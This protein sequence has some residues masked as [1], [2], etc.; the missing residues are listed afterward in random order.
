M[1]LEEK[2]IEITV[3]I[4]QDFR[5]NVV[6]AIRKYKDDTPTN[7][8]TMKRKDKGITKEALDVLC[9]LATTESDRCLIKYYVCKSQ[10]LSAKK[11]KK[12]YGFND[13]HSKEDM[14]MKA[15]EKAQGIRDAV[16]QL[17]GVRNKATL[18]SLG[19]ELPSD[20]SDISDS[21]GSD[22]DQLVS[23]SDLSA[24]EC[25]LDRSEELLI[26]QS[27]QAYLE[28]ER[29]R[30]M[31]ANS[32]I[33]SDSESDNPDNWVDVDDISSKHAK[34]MVAKQWQILKR[35][36]QINAAKVIAQA[37]LLKRRVTKKV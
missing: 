15:V 7:E 37:G 20:D 18:R 14:I 25:D 35:R 16:M 11:A 33:V 6:V 27:R 31:E 29:L 13:L 28:R 5:R 32:D 22:F 21:E 3:G 9:Q 30:V 26:E 36:A 17:A 2:H 12:D 1:E 4:H 24:D 34:E 19:Y 8:E 23:D 10:G